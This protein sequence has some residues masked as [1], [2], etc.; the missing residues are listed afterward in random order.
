M[1]DTFSLILASKA[2]LESYRLLAA[3]LDILPPF[4]CTKS[5]TMKPVGLLAHGL[6]AMA[7]CVG[8][9]FTS[10]IPP[11]WAG[12][13]LSSRQDTDILLRPRAVQS[14]AASLDG[15]WYGSIMAGRTSDHYTSEPDE[16]PIQEIAVYHSRGQ[17]RIYEIRVTWRS[18]RVA[19]YGSR[20]SAAAD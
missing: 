13:D 10:S 17:S 14:C 15:E 9:A 11:T 6:V 18:G 5:L 4:A 2:F 19:R 1:F 7:T 20:D 8:L 3:L 16:T 12:S